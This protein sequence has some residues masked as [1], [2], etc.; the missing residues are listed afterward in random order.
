MHDT[1][2]ELTELQGLLERLQAQRME[3]SDMTPPGATDTALQRPPEWLEEWLDENGDLDADALLANLRKLG[4]DWIEGFNE[5]LAAVKP[6]S[7]VAVF[8]LGV[9][10]GRLT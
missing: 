9:L 5:D 4:G 10:F 6:S 1:N 7:V 8:A 2:A 3:G